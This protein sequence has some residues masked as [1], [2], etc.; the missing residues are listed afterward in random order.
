[1]LDNGGVVSIVGAGGKTSLMYKLAHEFADA[2]DS[3]LTTTTTKI[4]RPEPEQCSCVFLS[5]S[6][7]A[8]LKQSESLLK[9]HQHITAAV[10][11]ASVPKKLIGFA[12]DEID[13]IWKS[14][15]FRWI[16]VEA[17]GA[18]RLPLK[19]PA[20][21]EPVFPGCTKWAIGVVGLSAV[22]QP[23]TDRTVFRP[24]IFTQL[25]GLLPGAPIDADAVAEALIQPDGIFKDCPPQT[26]RSVFLNQADIS[27]GINVGRRVTAALL[28]RTGTGLSQIVVGQARMVPPVLEYR[29]ATAGLKPD[30]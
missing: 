12:P 15:L 20:P 7:E 30:T 13:L 24:E 3:V 22:G 28:A 11:K 8:V 1:M 9:H 6:I 16:V 26:I 4:F 23:L 25:T 21:H 29:N 27:Q 10:G 19:A 17:D 14:G 5:D 2:G 18:A